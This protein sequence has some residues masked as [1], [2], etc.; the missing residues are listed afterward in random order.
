MSPRMRWRT[1]GPA[2]GI[3]FVLAIVL[4]TI[5]VSG[6]EDAV[7]QCAVAQLKAISSV[8]KAYLIAGTSACVAGSGGSP[9]PVD[10]AKLG[11]A[12]DK[13][14]TSIQAAIDKFGLDNCFTKTPIELT[15]VTKLATDAAKQLCLVPSPVPSSTPTS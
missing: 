7:T 14:N 4:A 10:V 12:V 5:S 3:A 9:Q 8:Y 1:T 11:A 13:A 15:N 6:A 2:I